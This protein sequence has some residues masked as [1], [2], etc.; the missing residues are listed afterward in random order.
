MNYEKKLAKYEDKLNIAFKKG[1]IKKVDK[2]KEAMFNLAS[3]K[4]HAEFGYPVGRMISAQFVE[5]DGRLTMEVTTKVI[6]PLSGEELAKILREK[7][8]SLNYKKEEKEEISAEEA[9][10]LE[11]HVQ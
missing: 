9:D 5:V 6:K 2:I 10:L 7:N 1:K 11:N 3:Q 4:I 8:A